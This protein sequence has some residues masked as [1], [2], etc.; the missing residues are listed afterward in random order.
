MKDME[1]SR[2]VRVQKEGMLDQ[3]Y[4]LYIGRKWVSKGKYT[5]E[6]ASLVW[7]QEISEVSDYGLPTM[8]LSETEAQVLMDSLWDSGVRPADGSGSAGAM[9]ATQ[10]HLKDMQ[11]IVFK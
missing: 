6:L 11:K 5:G 2:I 4:G 3:F 1:E 8:R 9:S 7:D 10:N